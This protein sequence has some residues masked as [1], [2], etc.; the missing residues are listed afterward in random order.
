MAKVF[1]SGEDRL[2]EVHSVDLSTGFGGDFREPPHATTCIENALS[3]KVLEAPA[4][5]LDER[6]TAPA[7]TVRGVELRLREAV[8]F[9]AERVCVSHF[10]PMLSRWRTGDGELGR[11]S[12]QE[13]TPPLR[14]Q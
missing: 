1:S 5:L 9:K 13:I 12:D 8:P 14:R 6:V 7:R 3:S 10:V 11:G 2:A 4:C